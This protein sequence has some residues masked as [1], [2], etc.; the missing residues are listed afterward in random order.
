MVTHPYLDYIASETH[1]SGSIERV[2]AVNRDGIL[3]GHIH[4][5]GHPLDDGPI[6]K[7]SGN[8]VKAVAIFATLHLIATGELPNISLDVEST[9]TTYYTT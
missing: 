2:Y 8:T 5:L 4:T 1:K 9:V 7:V 6:I 3:I